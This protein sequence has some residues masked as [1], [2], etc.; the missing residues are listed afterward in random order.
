MSPYFP[1]MKNVLIGG[2]IHTVLGKADAAR[3]KSLE[4]FLAA[5]GRI[6]AAISR[7]DAV[8]MQGVQIVYNQM[9]PPEPQG[10]QHVRTI[11]I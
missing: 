6:G 2:R 9:F 7:M 8:W 3:G 4:V 11:P 10:G 5:G 1:T